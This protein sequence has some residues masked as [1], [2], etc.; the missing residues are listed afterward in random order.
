MQQPPD[1]KKLPRRC[2]E[3]SPVVGEMGRPS[4]ETSGW[5]TKNCFHPAA[6]EAEAVGFHRLQLVL[7]EKKNEFSEKFQNSRGEKFNEKGKL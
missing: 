1:S 7:C 4:V 2:P 5:M 3:A 6:V